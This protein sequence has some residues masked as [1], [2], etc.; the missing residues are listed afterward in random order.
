M[1][2][3]FYISEKICCSEYIMFYYLTFFCT[4]KYL[5]S[6]QVQIIKRFVKIVNLGALGWDLGVKEKV[7][8][9]R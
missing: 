4:N 2:K 9:E 5:K 6:T 7:E 8:D 1:C 3:Q